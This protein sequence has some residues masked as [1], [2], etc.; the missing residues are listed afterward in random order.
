M[1]YEIFR[2]Q[3]IVI[4]FALAWFGGLIIAAHLSVQQKELIRSSI[5]NRIKGNQKM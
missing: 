3:D 2:P 5:K 1:S 4:I